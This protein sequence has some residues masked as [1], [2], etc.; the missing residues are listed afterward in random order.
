MLCDSTEEHAIGVFKQ[1]LIHASELFIMLDHPS[2]QCHVIE[3]ACRKCAES[4]PE[5]K[6]LAS[7]I[8]KYPLCKRLTE[9]YRRV[10]HMPNKTPLSILFEYA[11]RLNLQ[12]R[13]SATSRI[14]IG[15]AG[16][17]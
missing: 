16:L 2:L 6:E 4:R 9:A 5:R 12:V 14:H 15:V 17:K 3:R 8:D 11:S 7:V 10:Y 1:A 13:F